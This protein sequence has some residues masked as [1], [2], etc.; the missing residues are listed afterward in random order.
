M[1]NLEEADLTKAPEVE[2]EKAPEETEQE[3]KVE[4]KE[5]EKTLGD[6]LAEFP[7]SPDD[8]QIEVWKQQHGE[9][10]CSGLSEIELFVFRPITREEFVNLQAYIHQMGD[11]VN[12]F[13]IEQKIVE[14]CVL[15][16]SPPAVEALTKKAGTF[17]TVH[18]QILQASNFMNPAY[19]SQFVIKL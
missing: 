14:T 8:Q 19:V 18:E 5:E 15:W 9:V 10:L 2:E 17:G 13:E 12:N 1:S 4:K 3:E 7:E 6:Y 11:K 16:A